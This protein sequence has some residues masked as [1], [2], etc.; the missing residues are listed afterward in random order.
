MS[1]PSSRYLF[2]SAPLTEARGDSCTCS[3]T[4]RSRCFNPLPSPKQGETARS[5]WLSPVSSCF[6]PLPSPKQGET[7]VRAGLRGKFVLF[8][9]APLTEARGDLTYVTSRFHLVSIRSPH[10][11]KGR[12]NHRVGFASSCFNPLPS[13]KQGETWQTQPFGPADPCFNPLPSPKQGET[14]A[15]GDAP[16]LVPSVVFAGVS[17]R[18]PH[19]SKGRQGG[20]P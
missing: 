13:P 6:N 14:E 12:A 7:C 8:Q 3:L 9:S 17:I 19:R 18:S 4:A 2:Q 16:A 5:R 20:V 10:R 15:R 1:C 11:S